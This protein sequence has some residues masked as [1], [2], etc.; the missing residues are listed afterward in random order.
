VGEQGTDTP[1][2]EVQ[3]CYCGRGDCVGSV[4]RSDN[5]SGGDGALPLLPLPLARSPPVHTA[6]A[7]AAAATA[8]PADDALGRLDND[9]GT[10]RL[11]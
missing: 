9:N 4:C 3:R 5:N 8:F 1:A 10:T 6:A 11:A 2:S 7:A